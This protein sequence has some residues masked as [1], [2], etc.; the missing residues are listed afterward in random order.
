MKN[1]WLRPVKVVKI[2][3]MYRN[4]TLGWGTYRRDEAEKSTFIVPEKPD[5]GE[6]IPIV[7]PLLPSVELLFSGIDFWSNFVMNLKAKTSE[8]Q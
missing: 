4:T 2:L 1:G 5:I 7:K 8:K 6:F 3:Q